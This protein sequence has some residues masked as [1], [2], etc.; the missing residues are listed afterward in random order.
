M[1]NKNKIGGFILGF[2]AVLLASCATTPDEGA[3]Q[4][5]MTRLEEL[6]HF[7]TSDLQQPPSKSAVQTPAQA[8]PANVEQA[9]LPPSAISLPT[10]PAGKVEPRFDIAVNKAD[11]RSFF[12][13]LVKDTP[14]N[15]IVHPDVK[16]K[17]SLNL[18]D[19]TIAEVMQM[20]YDIYGYEYELTPSGYIVRP[21]KL[22]SRM[23][24]VNY[25]N[26]TRDGRSETRVSSGQPSEA[27]GSGGSSSKNDSTVIGGKKSQSVLAASEVMTESKFNFWSELQTSL[28]AIIGEGDGKSV[29][30]SPQSGLVV[31]RAFPSDLRKVEQFLDSSQNIM[32]RQVIIEAKVLEVELSD[33]YQ[34][35][36]NWAAVSN[37]GQY[38]IGQTGGGQ[39][40]QEGLSNIAGASGNL[41]PNNFTPIAGNTASA[42]GGVFTLAASVKN[43]KGFFEFLKT[44]GNIQVLSSPRVSTVNNQKAVIKVGTDEFFVTDVSSTTTTG[45]SSTTSP[46]VTLT[47][48]FSGISLDVTPQIDENGEIILHIHPTI[49]EVVDQQKTISIT[50]TDVLQLP[51][52]FS[53]VRESDSIVHAKNGQIVVIGGL[54][55]NKLVKKEAATPILSDIPIL[56]ALFKHKI[57]SEVK[58]EL[59]IL[60]RPIVIENDN[61][62]ADAIKN[63][64]GRVK[65]IYHDYDN[66]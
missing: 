43:F 52:A 2:C 31:V 26:I 64:S 5:P 56:G 45:V 38:T 17:I 55:K 27:G 46:Q 58:S 6:D 50:T 63:S 57:D 19:V 20:V 53:T 23:F 10:A 59:V 18:K 25:L 60:L 13:S 37:N 11:A 39:I 1:V 24:T 49:S 8:I 15:I 66:N 47:P 7:L 33:G 21:N 42:F 22:Q 40:F 61:Q 41:D 29:V 3:Q 32:Q 16:G 34:Q 51:L 62:W 14:Y 65:Q 4:T 28:K 30:I 35:G 44:Q 48:F 12:L 9:L 36:I 54:M